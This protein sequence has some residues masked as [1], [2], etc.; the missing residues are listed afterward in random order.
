MEN[1]ILEEVEFIKEE[2]YQKIKDEM[3][4]EDDYFYGYEIRN[5]KYNFDFNL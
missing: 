2:I 5:Y 3:N 4:K 1:L